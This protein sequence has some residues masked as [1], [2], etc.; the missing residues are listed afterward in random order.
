[1]ELRSKVEFGKYVAAAMAGNG[2]SDGPEREYNQH[3]G[4]ADNY[5]PLAL[6]A[7][8]Y[9]ERA[10]RD[11]DAQA[12]Q[13]TWLDR[14]FNETAAERVGISFRPVPPGVSTYPRHYGGRRTCPA[15]TYPGR[16]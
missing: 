3:L 8:K 14:V 2:V 5:F 13:G 4:I 15:R 1:M 10:A 11:G 6:L 16:S 9:E 12:S 7:G